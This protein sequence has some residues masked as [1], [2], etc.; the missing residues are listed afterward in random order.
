MGCDIY[1]VK[2]ILFACFQCIFKHT[3]TSF[4][5]EVA[6]ITDKYNGRKFKL[7]KFKIKILL[8]SMDI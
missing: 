6:R 3:M 2:D 5:K 8:V 7:W 4:K 1:K